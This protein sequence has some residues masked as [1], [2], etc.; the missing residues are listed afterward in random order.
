MSEHKFKA[1]LRSRQW[2]ENQSKYFV[3]DALDDSTL[4]DAKS[5]K[6]L[7]DHLEGNKADSKTI[8]EAEYIFFELYLA[9]Q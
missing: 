7:K 9:G 5:W 2:N 3:Y 4:P 1:F 6:E 8:E